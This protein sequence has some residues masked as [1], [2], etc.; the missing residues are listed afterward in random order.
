MS[1]LEH[2]P[3]KLRLFIGFIC[4]FSAV[5]ITLFALFIWMASAFFGNE[6]LNIVLSSK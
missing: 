2:N 1:E 6:I 4:G 3:L 5:T